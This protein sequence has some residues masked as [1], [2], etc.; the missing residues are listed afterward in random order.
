MKKKQAEEFWNSR[1]S[2]QIQ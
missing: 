2:C 1:E